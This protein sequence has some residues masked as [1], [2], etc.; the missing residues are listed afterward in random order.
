MPFDVD[1]IFDEALTKFEDKIEDKVL[2]N[3]GEKVLVEVFKYCLSEMEDV[4]FK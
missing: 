3:V 4:V 1:H 2:E